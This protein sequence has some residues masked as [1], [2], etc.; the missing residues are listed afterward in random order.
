MMK[1]LLHPSLIFA[2]LYSFLSPRFAGA[3][4]LKTGNPQVDGFSNERLHHIDSLLDSFTKD[5]KIAGIVAIAAR[6]GHIDYWNA[7]GYSDIKA[8]KLLQKTDMF[9]IASQTKA[10]TCVGIL[11]LYQEGKLLLDDP[12]SKYIPEF[13]N[14]TVRKT[15]NPKDSSYTTEPAKR[16]VTIH[17]LL[18]H[19]SGIGY[20]S[21]GSPETRAIYAK[22]GLVVGFEPRRIKLAD[23]MKILGKMPLEH[24]PGE[25]YT[26]GLNM[27]VL[28]RIIEVVSGQ[29]LSDFF[30]DRIFRPLGM[31]DT[32]FY[33]PE[34][35]QARVS[36]VFIHNS[37]GEMV[38]NTANDTT[39]GPNVYY[40]FTK[41]GTYFSGGAG[42]TSTAYDYALFLQMVAN[43]GI[44]NGKRILSPEILH[45]MEVNQIGDINL[46]YSTNKI[47]F[48]FEVITEKGAADAPWHVGT[49]MGG[50]YWGSTYWFDPKSD[51]VVVIWTQ[52]GGFDYAEMVNKFKAMLYGSMTN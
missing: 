25:S 34:S 3:Q 15:F 10:I 26:Y 33:V 52:S 41:N 18:T 20:A 28:G 16:E 49:N 17:D 11:I 4:G 39:G 12:V 44:L 14:P 27:D 32:Y 48:S 31:N 7:S 21:I 38:E 22:A 45:L 47:G 8:N 23:K 37:R 42:L 30:H 6:H 50:G 9:R 40:P 19:T 35:K 43:G 1:K 5:H 2:I 29:T 13:K 36:K 24:Q 51:M 46:G